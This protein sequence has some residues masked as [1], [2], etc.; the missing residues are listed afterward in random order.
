MLD[1][2]FGQKFW[3]NSMKFCRFIE[4][5]ESLQDKMQKQNGK[6]WIP[7]PIIF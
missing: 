3:K 2:E 5:R 1:F 7:S 4:I 6:P